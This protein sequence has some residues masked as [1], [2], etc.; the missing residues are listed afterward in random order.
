[1]ADSIRDVDFIQGERTEYYDVRH[2]APDESEWSV[3]IFI[4]KNGDKRMYTPIEF[5]NFLVE[6]HYNG[7]DK[8][9]DL[10]ERLKIVFNARRHVVHYIENFKE[11]LGNC[12][13]KKREYDYTGVMKE[14]DITVERLQ[15]DLELLKYDLD[16]KKLNLEIKKLDIETSWYKEP[17]FLITAAITLSGIAITIY[18]SVYGGKDLPQNNTVL[19]TKNYYNK[20]TL[21]HK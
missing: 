16:V 9:E 18:T 14:L 8:T 11:E 6:A 15:L 7:I 5:L 19:N 2:M 3:V 20:D 12:V 17:L 4:E 21:R 1:M 10:S 13:G